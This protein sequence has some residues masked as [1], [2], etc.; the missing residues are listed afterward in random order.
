MTI[1]DPILDPTDDMPFDFGAYRGKTPRQ[2]LDADP[3]YIVYVYE[4]I[5]NVVTR[6]LYLDACFVL[7]EDPDR[8]YLEDDDGDDSLRSEMA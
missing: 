3:G 5:P 8:H 4:N 1:I 7:E 2:V 6:G